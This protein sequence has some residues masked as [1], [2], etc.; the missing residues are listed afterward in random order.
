MLIT[1]AI[2]EGTM[3][4]L[5][6][7]QGGLEESQEKGLSE[8]TSSVKGLLNPKLEK[9]RDTTDEL[10]LEKEAHLGEGAAKYHGEDWPPNAPSPP[11][12]TSVV[13]DYIQRDT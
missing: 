3:K 1:D 12:M 13:A 11:P 7:T 5:D 6:I 4:A 2:D 10:T 8:R 9:Y